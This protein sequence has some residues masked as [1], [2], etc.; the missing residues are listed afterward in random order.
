MLRAPSTSGAPSRSRRDRR[1]SREHGFTILEVAMATFV[2]AFGIAT[3]IIAM[4]SGYKMIDVAR[5]TTL[6]SQVAQ[7]EMERI[8]M[9]SWADIDA[10][11]EKEEVDLT[12]VFT[13]DPELAAQFDMI[14]V[15]EDVAGKEDTQREITLHVTWTSYDGRSHQRTF[16]TRY[17]KNGLYDYYYTLARP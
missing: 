13:T 8:R 16:R 2:M 7:S 6:A 12:S 5:G 15:A 9:L 4:Q 10:L 3:T 1:P 14:R 17:S 11:P